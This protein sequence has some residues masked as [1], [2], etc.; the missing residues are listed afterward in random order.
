MVI[1]SLQRGVSISAQVH[2]VQREQ[3]CYQRAFQEPYDGNCQ[4][5]HFVPS[6]IQ[7]IEES[8]LRDGYRLLDIQQSVLQSFG[9]SKKYL[10]WWLHTFLLPQCCSIHCVPYATACIHGT[11]VICSSKGIEECWGT[12][13][14]RGKIK[15]LVVEWRR[16]LVV[17]FHSYKDFDHINSYGGRWE[18]WLSRYFAVRTRHILQTIQ[19]TRRTGQ[20][21]WVSETWTQQLDQSLWILEGSFWRFFPFLQHLILNGM[22]KQLWW[23]NNKSTMEKF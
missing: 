4:Q 3:S 20:Y 21:I 22:D 16:M 10:R 17:F 5:L 7:M 13:L 15:Q 9:Q 19:A 11:Y 6:C 2:Q 23:K 8:V 1:V 14:L 18:L 12:Y